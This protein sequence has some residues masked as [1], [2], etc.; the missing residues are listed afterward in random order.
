MHFL[1]TQGFIRSLNFHNRRWDDIEFILTGLQIILRISNNPLLCE[2][3]WP[4]GESLCGKHL[5]P[6]H[7]YCFVLRGKGEWGGVQASY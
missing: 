3:A 5:P 6:R 4:Y 2:D 1:S 7:L